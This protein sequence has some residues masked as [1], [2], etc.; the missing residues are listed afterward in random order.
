MSKIDERMEAID[1]VALSALVKAKQKKEA[2]KELAPGEY[3]IDEVV[4]VHGLVK[5][6]E[7]YSSK[8]TAKLL[9][10]RFFAALIQG[11]G[12]TGPAVANMVAEAVR[13]DM[14]AN[15]DET[16]ASRLDAKAEE[17]SKIQAAIL[18]PIIDRLPLRQD[19]GKVITDLEVSPV[20]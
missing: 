9:S 3:Q 5:V 10:K 20:A 4:R 6:G 7:D 19:K 12:V 18:Q 2:R 16:V 1:I 8:P 15:E 17:I 13:L 11:S 14:L